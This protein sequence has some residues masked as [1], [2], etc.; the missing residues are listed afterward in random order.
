MVR[1]QFAEKV[2]P[3]SEALNLKE[4]KVVERSTKKVLMVRLAADVEGHIG[5]DGLYYVL[6][7]ARTQPP[8][9]EILNIILYFAVYFNTKTVAKKM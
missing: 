9:F 8:R 3:L 6:D 2:K 4:H 1:K 5:S 7:L